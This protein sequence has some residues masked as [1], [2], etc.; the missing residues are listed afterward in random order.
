M[1]LRVALTLAAIVAGEAAFAEGQKMTVAL[2]DIQHD[3]GTVRV[4]LFSDPKTF[5]KADQAFSASEAPAKAGT[6]T[7]VF[8]EVPPGQY[9]IMAYHDENDNGELD[10]RFGMFPTEGYGL[11][12]NPKVMGPP[13]FED[14][15]FE[16]LQNE[17]SK[18][19]IDI[20]Y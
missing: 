10:R 9:A 14:S 2:N 18:I 4:A 16:V 20:R 15:Q 12:N 7:F 17:P 3:H 5:R 19:D 13:A 1:T 11:S 8:E 6:V